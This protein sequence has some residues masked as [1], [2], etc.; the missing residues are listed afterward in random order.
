[1][2]S[3][4]QHNP[5]NNNN[6]DEPDCAPATFMIRDNPDTEKPEIFVD[7][8]SVPIGPGK[9]KKQP[10][11]GYKLNIQLSRVG[12]VDVNPNTGII[13][14]M[15]KAPKN[16]DPEN[17]QSSSAPETTVKCLIT[18]ELV[19]GQDVNVSASADERD[20]FVHHL[21]VLMEWERQRRVAAQEF[22]S[23]ADEQAAQGG[24]FLTQR[25]S[26][27]AHFAKRELEL[28]TTKRQRESRKAKLVAEGGG[29]LKYTALAMMKNAENSG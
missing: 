3:D 10:A 12:Q 19:K 18:L 15:A 11:V 9:K 16:N 24:N 8:L 2:G 26:Q 29:G 23:I 28:Q 5:S 17:Q 21:L 25:A 22:D 14:I 7:P 20:M 27:A 6:S 1:M 4:S 13:K